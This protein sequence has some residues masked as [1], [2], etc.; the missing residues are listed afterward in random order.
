MEPTFIAEIRDDEDAVVAESEK[1][2][3]VRRK[4]PSRHRA[5]SHSGQA[6]VGS[7]PQV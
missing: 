6:S 4:G 5:D 2:V 3:H 7:C 1:R